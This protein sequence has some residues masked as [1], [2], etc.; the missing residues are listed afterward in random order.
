MAKGDIYLPPMNVKAGVK[1][2][3]SERNRFML[4]DT[5]VDPTWA[6]NPEFGPG[7]G[8]PKLRPSLEE[9]L[10]TLIAQAQERRQSNPDTPARR[11]LPADPRQK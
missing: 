1:G 6:S 11:R 9:R 7:F 2:F 8:D 3:N 5:Q 10:K 4:D